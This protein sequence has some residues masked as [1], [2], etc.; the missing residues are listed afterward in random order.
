MDSGY[1]KIGVMFQD[2]EDAGQQL[3]KR[4]A[5][6]RGTDAVVLA[7]PRGGV[8]IGYEIVRALRLPLDIVVTRKIGHPDN[9]EYALCAVDEK[10]TLL[11]D[12]AERESVGKEWLKKEVERQRKEAER[13]VRAYRGKEEP[14]EIKGKTAIIVDDGIATGLTMRLA[15]R[16]VKA[17][18]PKRVVV[19]VPVA[20]RDIVQKL[21]REVD[22]LIVLLPPE[23][24][25]GAVGAHYREFEQVED[26][27]VIRL[28]RSR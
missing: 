18:M 14:A 24:F 2:R 10:G 8:V 25:A 3:A 19:A 20:P 4:L 11:C 6:Y 15:V 26:D 28:L 16:A 5:H 12:E 7:L 17:E 21:T 27:T 9:P 13:R 22:E 1:D 23:E